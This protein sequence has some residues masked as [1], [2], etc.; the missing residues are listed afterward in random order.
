[1]WFYEFFAE[2]NARRL[3]FL[4]FT[5][6]KTIKYIT[7]NQTVNFQNC[8]RWSNFAS[9]GTHL[10]RNP[11][12]ICML[13]FEIAPG[14]W[15]NRLQKIRRNISLNEFLNNLQKQIAKQITQTNRRNTSPKESIETNC[16]KTSLKEFAESIYR[17]KSLKKFTNN[18]PNTTRKH[19]SQTQL[20][21]TTHKHNW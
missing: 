5:W 18:L 10:N 7:E 16:Q 8:S 3:F 19:N 13:S 2:Q 6:N 11:L 9:P 15:H 20:K 4:N 21:N 17:N 14:D 12:I 1:M